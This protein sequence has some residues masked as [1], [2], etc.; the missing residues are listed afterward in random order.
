MPRIAAVARSDP[1]AIRRLRCTLVAPII[2][3]TSTSV[4]TL[5]SMVRWNSRE[6]ACTMSP[7][8]LP[9]DRVRGDAGRRERRRG[10]VALPCTTGG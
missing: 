2:G 7:V 4:R 3:C 5:A 10:A 1:H 9:D 6:L 8:Q